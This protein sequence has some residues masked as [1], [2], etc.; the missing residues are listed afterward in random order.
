M[1][2]WLLLP[3]CYSNTNGAEREGHGG[4][5]GKPAKEVVASRFGNFGALDDQ[6]SGVCPA[7]YY[8]PSGSGSETCVS[9]TTLSLLISAANTNA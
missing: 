6:G 1:P 8:C 4:A 9:G 7:G 3:C 5:I 2:P